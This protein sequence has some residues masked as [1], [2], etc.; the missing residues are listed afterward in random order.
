M[1]PS[2]I[3][4]CLQDGIA[5]QNQSGNACAQTCDT[6]KPEV[7]APECG[8]Q[9]SEDDFTRRDAAS[10]KADQDRRGWRKTVRNFTPS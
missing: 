8:L 5:Q 1:D 9:P 7:A 6:G 2:G 10:S 4:A 3:R